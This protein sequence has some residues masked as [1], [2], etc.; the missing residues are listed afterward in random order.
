[1]IAFKFAISDSGILK[2][3]NSSSDAEFFE[4][5]LS[6]STGL[7]LFYYLCLINSCIDSQESILLSLGGIDF[8]PE[9]LSNLNGD[10]L[11]F[12]LM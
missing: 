9:P 4:N 12:K 7:E 8:L 3:K 6:F 1:M 2:E 5:S 10:K 11:E